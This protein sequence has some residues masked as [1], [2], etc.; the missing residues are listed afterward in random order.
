MTR[1]S[2]IAGAALAA[3]GARGSAAAL[4]GLTATLNDG[5][6]RIRDGERPVL[7]Y[8]H[9]LVHGP[10]GTGELLARSGYIHP[11]HAPCGAVVTDDFAP[12]HPHQ[13]GVFFAWTKTTA[14]DL[15]PDFW[16]LGGGTAR[17]RSE[18]LEAK[19]A[20][21]EP[22]RF[23]AIH[24][25]EAKKGN[26][27]L[28]V[29]DEQWEV[30]VRLPEF[31]DPNGRRASYV[32]DLTSRQTPL[33][34]IIL[35]KY[36]YGGMAVRGAREWLGKESD[37]RVL[38]SEGKDRA[39]A[40]TAKARWV[41]MSGSL[42]GRIAGVALLEHPSNSEA[43]NAVRMHPDVPYYVYA[44][45]QHHRVVLDAGRPHVF[46]YRI[47]AH[48]GPADPAALDALWKDFAGKR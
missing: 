29:L 42:G 2:L 20:D 5:V 17:I 25:W 7:S 1:R 37:F 48:N 14:G 39:A 24:A 15:Q 27:W 44:V 35:E 13:R 18:K 45:S 19:F 40:D 11:L 3:G 21:D 16:N 30:V 31:S 43:P 23:T 32:V 28:R 34:D 26:D 47:V 46:R 8:R 36:R 12:D 33:V 22:A 38:T 10:A 4:Q 6:L 41:D 9:H